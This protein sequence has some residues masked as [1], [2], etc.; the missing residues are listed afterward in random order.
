MFAQASRPA[1]RLPEAVGTEA[2]APGREVT[3]FTTADS[4]VTLHL[5]DGGVAEGD[6]LVR[7]NGVG[8]AIRRAL[9]ASEPTAAVERHRRVRGAALG[10]VG[11]LS[12]LSGV[13]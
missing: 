10:A 13:Y 6:L 7:S 11:H 8:S 1:R 4:R 12:G 3:G 9:H 2:V 5:A